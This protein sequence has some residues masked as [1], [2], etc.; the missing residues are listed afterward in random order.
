[1]YSILVRKP[2]VMIQFVRTYR[3]FLLRRTAIGPL[4]SASRSPWPTVKSPS[5][6]NVSVLLTLDSIGPCVCRAQRIDAIFAT[7]SWCVVSRTSCFFDG[8]VNLRIYVAQLLSSSTS[9]RLLSSRCRSSRPLL[10]LA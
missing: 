7:T 2:N 4:G 6:T 9:H 1:M 3:L 5:A 10:D 8:C